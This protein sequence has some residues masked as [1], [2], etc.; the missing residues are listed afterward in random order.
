MK[1]L[2]MKYNAFK[3]IIGLSTYVAMHEISSIYVEVMRSK[4]KIYSIDYNNDN[5]IA[6]T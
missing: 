5:K 6:I 1:A 4:Q 2:V 3:M